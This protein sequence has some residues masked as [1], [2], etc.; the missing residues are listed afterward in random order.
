MA[1]TIK[2]YETSEWICRDI[3]E[4]LSK[5]GKT[6]KIYL[7]S[8]GRFRVQVIRSGKLRDEYRNTIEKAIELAESEP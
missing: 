6:A 3:L 2:D 1:K 8:T 5:L 7:Q 4:R